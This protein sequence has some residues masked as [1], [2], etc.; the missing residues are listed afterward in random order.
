MSDWHHLDIAEV[1]TRLETDPDQGL[2]QAE[3]ESGVDVVPW[4]GG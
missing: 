2:T 3:A 1:L 4:Y